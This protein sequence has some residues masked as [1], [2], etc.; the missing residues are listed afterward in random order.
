M[1]ATSKVFENYELT[2]NILLY[3]PQRDLLLAQRISKAVRSVIKTSPNTQRA[4]FLKPADSGTITYFE[5]EEPSGSAWKVSRESDKNE[6]PILNHLLAP[7][8]IT[9]HYLAF[10]KVSVLPHQHNQGCTH[11]L[12][13]YYPCLP[14][15]QRRRK[16]EAIARP[17]AS[18]RSMLITQPPP[19]RLEVEYDDEEP[20]LDLEASGGVTAGL[21]L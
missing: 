10:D 21:F 4:L 15:A 13:S 20:S 7:H 3:L 6:H 16:L 9:A 17:E 14:D 11:A 1:S 5:S 19:L 12:Y 8:I 18:W 2:E